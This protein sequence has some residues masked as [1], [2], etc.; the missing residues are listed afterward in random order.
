MIKK[1][2]QS[3]L[4]TIVIDFIVAYYCIIFIE[5]RKSL[6]SKGKSPLSCVMDWIY[7]NSVCTVRRM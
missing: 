5:Q 1:Q 3:I 6:R 7:T 4:F 2:V